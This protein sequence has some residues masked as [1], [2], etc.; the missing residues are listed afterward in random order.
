MYR[1]IFCIIVICFIVFLFTCNFVCAGK[2]PNN[3]FIFEIGDNIINILRNHNVNVQRRNEPGFGFDDKIVKFSD[4]GDSWFGGNKAYG[5]YLYKAYHIPIEARIEI[6]EYC[7]RIYE[8][9]GRSEQYTVSMRS[10]EF[11]P[12]FFKPDP[13]FE[14]TLKPEN[15]KK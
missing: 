12:E 11:K 10:Q 6:V 13:F 15:R 8:E 5:I 7:M 9:R 3:E 14:L 4:G 1:C 2:H